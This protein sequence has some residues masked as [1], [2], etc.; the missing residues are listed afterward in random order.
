MARIA[1]Y[2]ILAAL[3]G[4]IA[5]IIV[6]PI[7]ALTPSGDMSNRDLTYPQMIALGG[8][9]GM[10]LGLG[11]GLAEAL[12]GVS[13]KDAYKSIFIGLAVG[14]V[15]GALGLS[16]GNQ[17]IYIPLLKLSGYDPDAPPNTLTFIIVLIGRT[18]G[19]ALIGLFTGLAQG[20]STESTKKMINGAVG[21]F[22]G[23]A[24]GGF[25][26]QILWIFS[27]PLQ[28]LR[29]IGFM[30]TAGSAG[31]FIGFIE[32][33]TK[34]ASI[35][36]LKGRNEGKEFLV[37]KPET[38]VGRDE[39][40][41]I[42]IFGDPDVEPRHFL[43]KADPYRH[44]LH[45]LNTL[46]GTSVNGQKV[47]QHTLKDGD[48]IQIGMTKLL[49]RDKATRSVIPRSNDLY[50]T[51]GSGIPT[52]QHICPFCGSIKDASG[53]CSCS[54]NGSP[55]PMQPNNTAAE[56]TMQATVATQAAQ[57]ISEP[58]VGLNAG[59]QA[60]SGPRLTAISGPFANQVFNLILV[61]ETTIGRQSDRTISLSSDNT[62]SR[63]HARI[64]NEGGQFVI[65]DMG[66]ANGT[67]VNNN[68][69]TQH[70]L[71]TGDT[72]QIGSTKFRFEA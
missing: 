60:G 31:L 17:L 15:G 67:H 46:A 57:P 6:E 40:V 28:L 32:E 43:I 53:N 11:L 72:V 42:P 51:A 14:A 24:V 65:Y 62:V 48:I 61:G 52:S 29:M 20:L 36:H 10:F 37:Y 18:A 58:T 26:F 23:G 63:Q 22:I 49:F 1:R 34:R 2:L 25:V 9:F 5:W 35:V 70:I 3:G 21:G 68:R 38:V 66:S 55:P 47:K 27:V 16:L 8:I 44:V 69:I 71:Q 30:I 19:W 33:V 50:G 59:T 56:Q 4:L 12:S 64:V 54:V 7:E 45:D 39:L 13:R 41:D